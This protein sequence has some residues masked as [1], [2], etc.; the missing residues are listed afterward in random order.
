MMVEAR[1]GDQVSVD[2]AAEVLVVG[3]VLRKLDNADRHVDHRDV[4]DGRRIK[5]ILAVRLDRL[6]E[7][8]L[9][10]IDDAR[11]A[12]IREGVDERLEGEHL[13]VG[14]AA[15]HADQRE[16]KRQRIARA[17]ADDERDQLDPLRALDRGHDDHEEREERADDRHPVVRLRVDDFRRAVAHDPAR[18]RAG[19]RKADQR[20]NRPDDRGRHQLVDPAGADKADKERDD[21]VDEAGEGHA[22][23][24]APVAVILADRG[25]VRAEE[26]EGRA[27]EH[28]ASA[29]REEQIDDRADAG[30][31]QRRRDVRL[32]PVA[33]N[34]HRH[35]KRRRHDRDHLLERENECFA[36]LGLV[37][38][39][40]D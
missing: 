16:D 15:R 33:G 1:V 30:A 39:I 21:N 9:R 22:D 14:V 6:E 36:E 37:S 25:G 20:D 23:D 8:E 27:E 40:I 12:E 11:E 24:D 19:E 35:Q 7:E 10:V 13:Q 18:R 17:D 3:D 5:R 31:E 29:L 28:R 2:D 4:A 34:E 26:R 32:Q 38:H